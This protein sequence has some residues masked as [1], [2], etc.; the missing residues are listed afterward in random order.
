MSSKCGIHWQPESHKKTTA[1]RVWTSG[2]SYPDLPN[3]FIC[4][5]KNVLG[6]NE[7][8]NL[9]A[10]TS[11]SDGSHTF[12]EYNNS[13][14]AGDFAIHAKMND[15]NIDTEIPCSP[16]LDGKLNHMIVSSLDLQELSHEP[17][18]AVPDSDLDLVSTEID[19]H[20]IPSETVGP[21]LEPPDSGPCQTSCQFLTA[22]A[23]RREQRIRERLQVFS[24]ICLIEWSNWENIFISTYALF[25]FV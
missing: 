12:L 22:D 17:K 4:K 24:S 20:L 11:V 18:D 7:I 15:R 3:A 13:T 9:E 23:A 14:D 25:F 10:G 16:T 8:F 19:Q 1:Y 5:S 6:E 21:L 2:N